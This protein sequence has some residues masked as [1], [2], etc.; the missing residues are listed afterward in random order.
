MTISDC[1]FLFWFRK[2]RR[3]KNHNVVFDLVLNNYLHLGNQTL[4]LHLYDSI[5]G[6]LLLSLS[7]FLYKTDA[8][9]KESLFNYQPGVNFYNRDEG[10]L[11]IIASYSLIN[12]DISIVALLGIVEIRG[13]KGLF[14][15]SACQCGGLFLTEW[16]LF[17]PPPSSSTF[18][19][20]DGASTASLK[21][22]FHRLIGLLAEYKVT[23][24]L[25]P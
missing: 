23:V 19:V 20:N 22:F 9:V 6:E 4:I 17:F 21:G 11:E 7:L 3:G 2:L 8:K 10:I 13:G 1:F 5:A 25:V 15:S 16:D 14:C 18:P 24:M 12:Q